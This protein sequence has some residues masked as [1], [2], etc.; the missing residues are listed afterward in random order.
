V[1][2]YYG[3][4][5]FFYVRLT[6]VSNYIRIINQHDALFFLIILMPHLY[7][8]RAHFSPSSGGKVYNVAMVVILLLKRMSA[9]LDEKFIIILARRQSRTSHPS[10]QT[11][12]NFSSWPADSSELLIRARRQ[13]RTSHPGPQT[14]ANFSSRPADSRFKSKRTTTATLYFAS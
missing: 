5:L 4:I 8:F 13:S 7:M 11:V 6:R 3:F 1:R 12:T 10:P 9:G 2:K 14:V